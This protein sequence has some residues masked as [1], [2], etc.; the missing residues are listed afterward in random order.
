VASD[1]KYQQIVQGAMEVL[2]ESQ[3]ETTVTPV[4]IYQSDS[5]SLTKNITVRVKLTSHDRT[6][7]GDEVGSVI[8][9]V[10]AK[11]CA[12]TGAVVV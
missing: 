8:D 4:D 2:G 12:D 3:F 6:L 1:T 11:V 5:T 10:A 7:T 9:A